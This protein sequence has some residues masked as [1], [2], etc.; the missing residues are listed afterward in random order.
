M[1]EHLI[2]KVERLSWANCA[3]ALH[4]VAICSL[5]IVHVLSKWLWSIVTRELEIVSH[6][7]RV[8]VEHERVAVIVLIVVLH[9]ILKHVLWLDRWRSHDFGLRLLHQR[10]GRSGGTAGWLVWLYLLCSWFLALLLLWLSSS[11]HRILH[12][13]SE[14]IWLMERR[15]DLILDII[16]IL[17]ISLRILHHQ[18]HLLHLLP[19]LIHLLHLFL[20]ILIVRSLF[21]S[22]LGWCLGF[23]HF[24]MDSTS[25]NCLVLDS[26]TPAAW[27][28]LFLFSSLSFSPYAI[29]LLLNCIFLADISNYRHSTQFRLAP[30]TCHNG[31]LLGLLNQFLL[32]SCL[33]FSFVDDYL[34]L[35]L[36]VIH[37]FEITFGLGI[38]N[39][40]DCI[41]RRHLDSSWLVYHLWLTLILIILL[42]CFEA[43]HA[44]NLEG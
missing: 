30:D 15:A 18:L 21:L 23:P 8:L 38:D 14:I 22:F 13:Q 5:S 26:L 19:Q 11:R 41:W 33:G 17:R 4:V 10:S 25:R 37:D 31:I 28:C 20:R 44:T 27:R 3:I 12:L 1:H 39:L 9:V 6:R 32:R 40:L 24:C 7:S 36:V 43:F 29:F 35:F 42:L 16:L 34:S 2:S